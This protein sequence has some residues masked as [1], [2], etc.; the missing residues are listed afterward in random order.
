[1]NQGY[2]G[3]CKKSPTSKVIGQ[4]RESIKSKEN[5]SKIHIRKATSLG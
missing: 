3:I 5:L 2:S 1:M 4:C